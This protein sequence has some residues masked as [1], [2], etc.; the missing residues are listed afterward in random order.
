MECHRLLA[1]LR[2]GAISS[3]QVYSLL[4]SFGEA[5]FLE[6]KPDVEGYLKHEDSELRYV[7]LNVLA[8]HW[9]CCEHRKTCEEFILTDSE[10]E[11]RG[12]GTC[13]LG[14]LL[15]GTRDPN[16]LMLLLQV[17]FDEGEEWH[18]RDS[19]YSAILYVLGRPVTEQPSATR[20]LDYMKDVNWE[21]I[22]VAKEIVES[23]ERA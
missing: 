15:E 3:D 22:R 9:K 21:H 2:A 10:S 4:H 19:A 13:G 11:N 1:R 7:A 18:V 14:A 17:F 16:A 8:L 12:L 20:K 23:A 6:A 5:G